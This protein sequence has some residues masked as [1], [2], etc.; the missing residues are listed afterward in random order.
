MA[1]TGTEKKKKEKKKNE[2]VIREWWIGKDLEGS[3]RGLIL[4]NLPGIRL[5][6][7]RKPQKLRIAGLR[8]DI[9]TRDLPNTKQDC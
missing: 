5:E 1:Q 2:R 7:L 9:W 3:G 8:A 6:G 4:R